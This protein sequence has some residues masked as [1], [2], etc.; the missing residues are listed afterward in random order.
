MYGSVHS[1]LQSNPP[2]KPQKSVSI[3]YKCILGPL[4]TK[5][6]VHAIEFL[7]Y[8]DGCH[9]RNLLN[10]PVSSTLTDTTKRIA[11]METVIDKIYFKEHIDLWCRHYCSPNDFDELKKVH[12]HM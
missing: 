11:A 7:C 3:L 5:K 12:V 2:K 4:L 8:D 10:N 1:L 6:M 9:L